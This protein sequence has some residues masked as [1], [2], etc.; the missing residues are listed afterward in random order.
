M[1]LKEKSRDL[2]TVSLRSSSCVGSTFQLTV[3][4]DVAQIGVEIAQLFFL[5][6]V[7]ELVV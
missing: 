6:V 3:A 1:S 4:G 2:L 5:I 7:G